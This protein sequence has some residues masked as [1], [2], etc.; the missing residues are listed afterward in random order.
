VQTLNLKHGDI[1]LLYTDGIEDSKRK[2]RDY[3]NNEIACTQGPVGTPHGNHLAGERTEVFGSKR[4]YQIVN[5][6][7]NR[8]TYRLYK[9][10]N[11]EE[12]WYMDFNFST[13]NGELDKLILALIAVEKMFRCEY[14]GETAKGE[15]AHGGWVL[16]EKKID[17]FLKEHL[18]QYDQ[19]CAQTCECAG[20]NAYMYYTHLREYDQYDDL[21]ILGVKRK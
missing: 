13:C 12:E 15:T 5:A 8:G 10:H 3:A 11:P 14:G 17:A 1:L 6:V 18:V 7:M 20:N 16:V 4:V 21:T 19:Y 9:W 2:F